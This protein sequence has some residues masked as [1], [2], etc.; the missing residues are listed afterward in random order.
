MKATDLINHE[1]PVVLQVGAVDDGS[2]C[3]DGSNT[4][5][6]STAVVRVYILDVNNNRP[7]FP[8]C[9]IYSNNAKLEEGVYSDNAPVIIRVKAIDNDTAANGNIVYTLYYSKTEQRHP[10]V[11]DSFTGDIRPA[12]GFLFDREQKNYEEV[13]VKVSIAVFYF[14]YCL[15]F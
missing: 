6:V 14:Y 13:T 5:H 1:S 10:F 11:I 3:Q 12:P 2:C 9:N 4:I 15:G 7:E 8:E